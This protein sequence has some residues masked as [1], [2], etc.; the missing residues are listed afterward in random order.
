MRRDMRAGGSESGT[1]GPARA[2]RRR[3]TGHILSDWSDPAG[4]DRQGWVAV[5]AVPELS[6]RRVGPSLDLREGI[7]YTSE[8]LPGS[9]AR[10]LWT[11]GTFSRSSLPG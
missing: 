7:P 9:R 6:H 3:V 1:I 8:G 5:G 11:G 10:M 4:G 2:R